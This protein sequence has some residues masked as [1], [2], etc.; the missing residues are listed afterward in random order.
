LKVA[1]TYIV[2][3]FFW[4][5][6]ILAIVERFSFVLSFDMCEE[7]IVF[8]WFLVLLEQIGTSYG[9]L[10]V[11]ILWFSMFVFSKFF[12]SDFSVLKSI[13]HSKQIC[14]VLILFYFHGCKSIYHWYPHHLDNDK[15]IRRLFLWAWMWLWGC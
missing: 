3:K 4:V 14:L 11:V 5:I 8:T 10:L 15:Y 9:I 2:G 1:S 7:L 6:P 12:I 13:A